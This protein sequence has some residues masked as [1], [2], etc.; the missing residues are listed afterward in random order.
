M[1]AATLIDHLRFRARLDPNGIAMQRL[2]GQLT[3]AALYRLVKLYALKFREAGIRPGQLV[4]T[5]TVD[6]A[7][8]WIATLALIH[9]GAVTCS[10]HGYAPW[11]A[12]ADYDWMLVDRARHA[13]DAA[14]TIRLAPESGENPR[15]LQPRGNFAGGDLVRLV[16]TSGTTGTRKL[17][18]LTQAQVIARAVTG[19]WVREA[20]SS[21][22]ALGLST[23]ADFNACV[24]CLLLGTPLYIA[25]GALEIIDLVRQ[26]S[27]EAVFGAPGQLGGIVKELEQ[28][29]D[30]LDGVKVVRIAGAAPSRPL[31]KQLN[32]RI[33][34][35][36]VALYGCTEA[37]SMAVFKPSPGSDPAMVGIVHV[38]SEVQ[39]VDDAGSPVPNGEEG[40]LRVRTPFMVSGYHCNPE[41][42]ERHFRGG[43]FYPG[44]RGRLDER[45]RL[46]LGGRE[47]EVLNRGGVKLNPVLMDQFL[48]TLPGIADAAV[49]RIEGADGVERMGAAI[50]TDA[51]LAPADLSGALRK[52]FGDRSVPTFYVRV[53]KI[54]RN[55]MGKVM[56]AELG[57]RIAKLRS[58]R[59][60]AGPG[61][62]GPLPS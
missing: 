40:V 48:A 16:L 38:D 10:N 30:R 41:D 45:G 21:V 32:E 6:K 20:Q 46:V 59:A 24:T 22:S 29:D 31:L 44:D 7:L 27:I 25:E 36:V 53:K 47:T 34:G 51:E 58:A 11:S 55:E 37:F 4:V 49:F 12:S 28:R 17:V 15:G 8:D 2:Q 5:S 3:H 1:A 57:R 43:W 23:A 14:R 42:T 56:R 19:L 9:E 18:P 13:F 54:P 50:V 33:S 35:N 61:D 60:A 26:F 52:E 62:S 39:V